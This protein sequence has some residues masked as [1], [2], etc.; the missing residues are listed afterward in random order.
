MLK[1]VY[2]CT[3][4]GATA[5]KW[6]GR[7]PACGEWN[8]LE[9]NAVEVSKKTKS[10]VSINHNVDTVP[11]SQVTGVEEIRYTTGIDELDRVL[12][13]GIVKGSG[14][15]LGGEPGSGKSTLLLEMCGKICDSAHPHPCCIL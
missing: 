6:Y 9:E 2:V 12:G 3:N 10:A 11:L 8:T 5:S 15:L 13:G 1:S 4:C 7:C 14:V